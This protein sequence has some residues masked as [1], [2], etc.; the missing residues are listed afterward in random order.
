MEG[1][2]GADWLFPYGYIPL[3]IYGRTDRLGDSLGDA[4][5]YGAP[6]GV[7]GQ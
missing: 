5:H 2:L 1:G 6:Y 4:E 7:P 3:P